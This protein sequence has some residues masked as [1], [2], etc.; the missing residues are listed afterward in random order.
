MELLFSYGTLQ[1]SEVQLATF[2]RTLVGHA[3]ELVGFAASSITIEDATVV[4]TSGKSQHLIVR[5][6]DHPGDRVPGTVF[7][8]TTEELHAADEY[9][10]AEYKRVRA[11]LASGREAWVYVDARG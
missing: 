11:P 1:Q 8:I 6:T 9:E 7:E 2:R 4:A 5:R 3:D 10:V